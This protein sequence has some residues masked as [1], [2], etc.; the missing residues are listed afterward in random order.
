MPFKSCSHIVSHWGGNGYEKLLHRLKRKDGGSFE[1]LYRH[2]LESS[3]DLQIYLVV[4]LVHLFEVLIFRPE[5][6]SHIYFVS[7]S[8][9]PR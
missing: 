6:S 7:I 4:K 1:I 5:I 2:D 9:H 3:S 8:H